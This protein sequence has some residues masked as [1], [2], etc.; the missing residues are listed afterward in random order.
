[1]LEASCMGTSIEGDVVGQVKYLLH[2][3]AVNELFLRS[4]CI[5]LIY[6]SCIVTLTLVKPLA[7]R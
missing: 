3:L 1:M 2:K 6:R 7:A 5:G 4:L